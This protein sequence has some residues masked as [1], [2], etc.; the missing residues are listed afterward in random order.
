MLGENPEESGIP[1]AGLLVEFAEAAVGDD[2]GRLAA[3]RSAVAS[4]MGA[5]ALADTAGV[6]ALFNAIDRVADSTGI[7]LEEEKAAMTED[8]REELGINAFGKVAET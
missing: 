6:A 5:D 7:P 2:P 1:D 3:A 4:R 8:F